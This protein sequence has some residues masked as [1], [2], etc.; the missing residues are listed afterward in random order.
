MNEKGNVANGGEAVID[1]ACALPTPKGVG[2][3]QVGSWQVYDASVV[4][5]GGWKGVGSSDE[6]TVP[7]LLA[8]YLRL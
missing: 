4:L 2:G 8:A 5:K 3:L 7:F 1:I 6:V